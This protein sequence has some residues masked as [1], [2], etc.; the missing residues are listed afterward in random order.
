MKTILQ[1]LESLPEP[2]RSQALDNSRRW[3][4][5]SANHK[6]DRVGTMSGSI[7]SAFYWARTPQGL[8]YWSGVAGHYMYPEMI[9]LPEP[10]RQMDQSKTGIIE[11]LT[12]R[13]EELEQAR[14]Q[15]FTELRPLFVGW[16][17]L[18]KVNERL[19]KLEDAATKQA[20]SVND[21]SPT[22]WEIPSHFKIQKRG[23][24]FEMTMMVFDPDAS[25][26]GIP[27]EVAL[28]YLKAG[29]QVRRMNWV[30]S[31]LR[32]EPRGPGGVGGLCMVYGASLVQGDFHPVSLEDLLATDW[33]VIP[34]EEKK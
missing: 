34:K 31:T 15:L 1:H 24:G 29:R 18:F 14:Q 23:D 16:G 2:Y 6:L 25:P 11:S 5:P 20:V 32:V 30:P 13:V 26:P 3:P 9:D 28:M 10:W 8:D 12:R 4:I 27:F 7:A 17:D 19:S 33:L 22:L 21:P